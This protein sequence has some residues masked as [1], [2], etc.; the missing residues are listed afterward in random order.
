MKSTKSLMVKILR[1]IGIPV[2]IAFCLTAV[3]LLWTVQQ[4]V[5]TITTSELTARSQ[6]VSNQIEAYLVKYL[7]IT[8]Q[9][10]TNPNVEQLML[11]TQKG[12]PFPSSPT[13][14]IV[15]QMLENVYNTDTD[16]ILVSWLADFD[17]SQFYQTDGY[18][19]DDTY[20]ITTRGWYKDVLIKK[21]AF[22]TEPYID[23]VSEK[24]IVSIVS[25]LYKSGT[26]DMIGATCIDISID[27]IRQMMV[28]N[29]IGQTGFYVLATDKGSVFY[30]PNEAYILGP[31]ADTAMSSNI[32]KALVDKEEGEISY[33]TDGVEAKGYVSKV[34]DTDWT[35]ATGLPDKEFNG[36]YNA[37]RNTMLIVF[38][39]A[40]ALILA[41]IVFVSRK[42]SNPIKELAQAADKLSLGDVDVSFSLKSDTPRDEVEELTLAFKRMAENIKEQAEAAKLIAEGDLSIEVKLRSDKDALGLSM[43]SLFSTLKDL[44]V[45]TD[46]MIEAAIHGDLNARG[47]A[48]KFSGEFK[49]IVEGFN[50]TLDAITEP[51]NE[52]AK[53]LDE[54]AVGNLNVSMQGDYMGDHSKIKEA[55]NST[56]KNLQSYI[57]EIS[58]VLTQ[59]GA[60]NLELS[61][62]SEYKGDFIEIK[63]SLNNIVESLSEVF[64]DI[65]EAAEQ[66]SAG[67]I[68]VSDGSQALSQGATEQASS[69]Q[70][71]SASVAE[72]ASQTKQ[73]AISAN[74]ANELSSE[75]KEFAE[76]GDEQMR[77]MLLS[78]K[79]INEASA[80][81]SKVIK[82]IDDIA[83]QTNILALNAAVEAAR[84]GQHGK[85][86]AVV[87]EE[88]RNLAARSAE[89][90]KE[91]TTL[92]EGSIEKVSAG[93]M[94]ASETAEALNG[95]VKKTGEAAI[96]VR[97]IADASN[98]QASSIA[99][100]DKGIE[101]VSQVVQ[102]NSAT[103]EESAAASEELSSQAEL[104]KDM[105]GTFK[106]KIGAKKQIGMF[107]ALEEP[108][109]EKRTQIILNDEMQDKY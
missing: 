27:Q 26:T 61:I 76:K 5:S 108:I 57:K 38:M 59:I 17:S 56:I 84:A 65:T 22:I 79:D 80:N 3:I 85:G 41:M 32:I 29:K 44:A 71:L 2:A 13:W 104:L 86:F 106:I 31:V 95:I 93:T 15:K 21:K 10:A 47:H 6:A 67:T 103:A 83:F 81:I 12:M 91:T 105:V 18:L 28:D 78:M 55:L 46:S 92:I 98:E 52:A 42:I 74:Q 87:A 58:Y 107:A 4:S 45:E 14:P 50:K 68:Q 11:E 60:R 89:A 33:E 69:V 53:V 16:N 51:F 39:L 96:L 90:A 97:N 109:Y 88:V 72:I 73:N 62:D 43:A 37:V 94:I 77:E 66:V 63:D 70:Q 54:V 19:S 7:E 1:L 34:G 9:M 30:H 23:T 75:A 40:L 64:S 24:T 36:T 82:V 25:P 8:K 48:D 101:Q 99:Q 35:L 102:S 100:I 20:D 49:S